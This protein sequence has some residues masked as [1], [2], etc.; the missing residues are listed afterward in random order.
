MRHTLRARLTLWNLLIVASA[1]TLFAVL[2]YA[3]LAKTLYGHHDDEIA[4]DA[5]RLVALLNASPEPLRR[6]AEIDANRIDPFLIVRRSDGNMVFGSRTLAPS[7]PNIGAHTALVHAAMHGVTTPQFFTV[8]L[9]HA[10]LVRF[11]CVPLA[12]PA[13]TYLQLGRPLG[14]V[15]LLLRVVVIASV[16]LVPLVVVLTSFGG[17]LIARR[18]LAPVDQIASTLE[19]IQA[20]DLSRRVDAQAPD[21]EISRLSTSINRLLDRLQR[22]F[23]SMKEFTAEVSH[24]LQTP[25]TV[26]KGAVDAA[27]GATG[28]S[29]YRS[30]LDDLGT[31]VE[32]LAATLQDLR[33]FSLAE[34][35]SSS[36][37][38]VDVSH[39]FEEAADVVQALAEAHELQCDTSIAPGLTAW[40]NA[41]RVRQVVLNLGENAVQF[42]PAGGHVRIEATNVDS[43]VV[44]VV[45]DTGSGIAP[46]AL[47]HVFERRYQAA[48]A[49]TRSGLGL[50]LAIVKRIVD[51]HGGAVRI[52]S[53][54]GAGT[55]VTVVLPAAHRDR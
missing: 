21:A 54:L 4:A 38:T 20:R 36:F 31:E 24:Q 11:I 17:L 26:M 53:T 50:G 37:E 10:G 34:A 19:S 32:A 22:S 49:G 27:T 51:A 15:D 1:L 9:D 47:N 30:T 7:E 39:V 3:W 5:G 29:D 43:N 6:L 18:A 28:A 8:R 12:R 44:L 23:E 14:D 33:D 2:L 35:D 40:G 13:G 25:L 48:G 16:V 42:T 55:T 45:Q 52:E 46:E 41:V